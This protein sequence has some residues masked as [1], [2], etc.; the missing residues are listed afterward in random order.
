MCILNVLSIFDYVRFLTSFRDVQLQQQQTKAKKYASFSYN[1]INNTGKRSPVESD[2]IQIVGTKPS[3]N[4][5][6]S[7]IGREFFYLHVD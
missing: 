2:E 1:K 4:H 7:P 5:K 3:S 6:F